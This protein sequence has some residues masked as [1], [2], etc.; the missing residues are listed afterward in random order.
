MPCDSSSSVTCIQ[1]RLAPLGAVA[2][3]NH[4]VNGFGKQV[5]VVGLPPKTCS[6][7][8]SEIIR[9]RIEREREHSTVPDI[10]THKP[11]KM[12]NDS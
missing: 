2:P 5:F 11:G 10:G 6:D 7:S 3:N 9:I 4:D 8:Y 1:E 12:R